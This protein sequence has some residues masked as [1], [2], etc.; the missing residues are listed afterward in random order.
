MSDQKLAWFNQTVCCPMQHAL[1]AGEILSR[2]VR[3]IA[4][5][6]GDNNVGHSV[7]RSNNENVDIAKFSRRQ[8]KVTLTKTKSVKS[9]ASVAQ[10]STSATA[11]SSVIKSANKDTKKSSP[12]QSKN[13]ARRARR[14]INAKARERKRLQATEDAEV[15]RKINRLRLETEATRKRTVEYQLKGAVSRSSSEE[16]W[17]TVVRCKRRQCKT[18]PSSSSSAA[19]SVGGSLSDVSTLKSLVPAAAKSRFGSSDS[20]KTT[21]SRISGVSAFDEHIR[22]LAVK[23]Q[24]RSSKIDEKNM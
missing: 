13:A 20:F 17:L 9:S 14:E 24:I 6:S 21:T 22:S 15:V 16:E 3:E 2:A 7:A 18:S 1:R 19:Q 23:A 12:A 4:E 5:L 10:Q 8:G 11:N